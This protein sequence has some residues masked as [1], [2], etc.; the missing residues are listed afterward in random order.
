M[1][2]GG[3]EGE[4][5]RA[6][7][8]GRPLPSLPLPRNAPESVPPPL[9]VCF[10]NEFFWPDRTGGTGTVLSELAATLHADHGDSVEID[11]I[12]SRNL[13]RR[14]SEQ[15]KGPLPEREAWNGVRICRV[16]APSAVGKGALSRLTANSRFCLS[17]L[18]A[19][20]REHWRNRYDLVVVGTAPPMLSAVAGIFRL[21]TRTPY[22]YIIYDLE[23]DRAVVLRVLRAGT[24]AT[25]ALHTFQHRWLHDAGKV[26]VLGRCMREH[27]VSA[28]GLPGE[29][30]AVIP[31]GSNPDEIRSLPHSA[32]RFR[33]GQG[34]T[35]AF[36]VLYSGNFGRYHDFDAILDAAK[37]V[38]S[39]RCKAAQIQFV[40][41]G[42]GAQ[43]KSVERRV[44][45]EAITNVRLLPFVEASHY[46]DL[47]A[48]A[49]VSL[50]TLEPG[51]EGLCV[52]SKFYSILASGRPVLGLM[53]ARC[54]AARV[55][56]EE[57]CGLRVDAGDARTLAHALLYLAANPEQC[58][59]MG[60]RS[61][62]ALEA[63]FTSGSVADLYMDT[64]RTSARK[65]P[66]LSEA[67]LA[68]R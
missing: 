47:L 51:M 14:S 36:V 31:I 55:I 6:R 2:I 56:A 67:P 9:R 30:V 63:R 39:S 3:I 21:L 61:R 13:Y 1:E 12:T 35:D 25:R 16:R 10:L 22:V 65:R 57:N 68:T 23:P 62:A 24:A 50:V 29:R 48:A 38:A 20:L 53:D 4:P 40:L 26:V 60:M 8:A 64:I 58:A 11:V 37:A 34:L 17:A 54:E 33:Q 27:L 28:Y 49:N 41:V 45:E 5:G 43:R 44:K 42:E 19:L 7:S 46:P 15:N 18:R 52:P 32:S 59:E 66:T